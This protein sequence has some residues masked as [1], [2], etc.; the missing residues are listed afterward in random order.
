MIRFAGCSGITIGALIVVLAAANVFI[1]TAVRSWARE[2]PVIGDWIVEAAQQLVYMPY[3]PYVFIVLG[4]FFTAWGI[5]ML[6]RKNWAR[7]TAIG[8]YGVGAVY[9]FAILLLL[10]SLDPLSQ[11]RAGILLVGLIIMALQIYFAW[12][13]FRPATIAEFTAQHLNPQD[14][15]LP[16]AAKSADRKSP[17][18]KS[19]SRDKKLL[20]KSPAPV[21]AQLEPVGGGAPAFDVTKNQ[22]TLGRHP[23]CD[24][25]LPEE[26]DRSVSRQHAKITLT[27]G[28][29]VLKDEGASAGTFVNNQQVSTIPLKNGDEIRLG[30]RETR[31]VFRVV[32][33]RVAPPQRK[34]PRL[35]H[36]EP[37]NDAET[38]FNM[39]KES[40]VIGRDEDE[41]DMVLSEEDTSTSRQHA[42]I[43]HSPGG[44]I[45]EDTS[46]NG[47]FVNSKKFVKGSA[48][49]SDGDE[50]RFGL[51]DTRFT[52]RVG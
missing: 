43:S 24:F 46:V 14:Y 4:V 50:I 23:D 47:T 25:V 12:G 22:V 6:S 1:K 11:Q 19:P 26:G 34:T 31:F 7:I 16:P 41:C 28:Q 36:L 37:E 42:R 5:A 9:T 3:A 35:A 33:S 32:G 40:I 20:D 15:D 10:M 17:R 30:A 29:F 2:F 18:R 51:R 45:L 21:L 13:M 38:P 49:L 27:G 44:F 48:S 52:F 8:L 39:V